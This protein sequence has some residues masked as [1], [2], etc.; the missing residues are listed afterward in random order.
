[1]INIVNSIEKQSPGHISITRWW[2]TVAGGH[3]WLRNRKLLALYK[4]MQGLH[5]M[6]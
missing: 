4:L 1:M 2:N 5:P 6:Y 3:D